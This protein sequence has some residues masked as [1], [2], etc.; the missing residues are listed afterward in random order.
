M[1][2]FLIILFLS[3]LTLVGC[4][5]KAMFRKLSP[6][7]DVVFAKSYLAA[8][9]ANSLDII[10]AQLDPALRSP[11]IISS[12][13]S[14]VTLFPDG[15]PKSIQ[16]VE[17]Q[18]L[19]NNGVKNISLTFEYEYP[20]KWVLATVVL[21]PQGA[22]FKVTGVRLKSLD[23]SLESI[24]RFNILGKDFINYVVLYFAILVPI[25]IL[26]SL[27][28]CI[29]APIARRKWAWILFIIIGVCTFRLNW[30]DGS[31]VMSFVAFQLFGAGYVRLGLYAPIML[32]VSFPL[33]AIIFQLR[34]KDLKKAGSELSS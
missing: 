12:L 17:I 26:A 25:F 18:Y 10:E 34:R 1:R 19:P 23:D 32:S 29:R 2:A 27:I 24:N 15:Q 11:Q 8:L 33:G 7:R 4:D 28:Q 6:E 3:M 31:G 5:Q 9:Q 13:Q 22:S 16:L 30:T 21:Q 14:M 20:S